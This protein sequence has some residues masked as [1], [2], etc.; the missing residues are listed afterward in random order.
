VI[1]LAAAIGMAV[2]FGNGT[3]TAPTAMEASMFPFA[4]LKNADK[5]LAAETHG[6]PL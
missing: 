3:W 2:R 1:F 4:L 5:K 6:E